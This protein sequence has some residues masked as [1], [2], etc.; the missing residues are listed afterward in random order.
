MTTTLAEYYR[1]R[2]CAEQALAAATAAGGDPAK[3]V[4]RT[5]TPLLANT[6]DSAGLACG[7]GCAHCC[8]FPVGVTFAEARSLVE[9]IEASSELSARIHSEGQHT[10]S[11]SWHELVGR[12]CPLLDRSQRCS[13]YEARP[14]PCRALGSKDAKACESAL[15][16]PTAVV[17]DEAAWWRG[18]G[19]ARAL[20]D[21]SPH[22]SRELRSALAAM[23]HA[24]PDA[25]AAAFLS[26]RPVPSS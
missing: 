3:A 23:L 2:E 4:H 18:L 20:G 12:P 25:Q 6:D 13:L 21:L 10:Q 11:A 1:G 14:M 7:S 24:E 9:S 26:A 17:R 5:I 8:S 22:G 15:T 19:A 16:K